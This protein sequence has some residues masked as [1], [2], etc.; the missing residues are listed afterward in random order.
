MN[1]AR[2]LTIGTSAEGSVG[3]AAGRAVARLL[4]DKSDHP[5]EARPTAGQSVLLPQVNDGLLDMGIANV[6]EVAEALRGDGVFAGRKQ[7]NIRALCVLF[8]NRTGIF[9]RANSDIRRIAD[10]KGK[11]LSYGFSSMTSMAPLVLAVLANGGLALEDVEPVAVANA[12]GGIDALLADRIDAVYS[13]PGA[14]RVAEADRAVGGLRMLSLSTEAGAIAAMQRIVPQAF[15]LETPA[16]PRLTGIGEPVHALAYDLPLLVRAQV[17]E[18]LVYGIAATLAEQGSELVSALG[19][20]RAFQPETMARPVP[21]D[22]HPGAIRYYREKG[23]WPP[24]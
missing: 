6:L 21:C 14:A 11:R 5:A 23:F 3:N 22:Y 15:A 16:H 12:N 20:F 17:A 4:S 19:D 24:K 10:L 18:E 8:P 1:G 2:S 7:A 9:V 13:A